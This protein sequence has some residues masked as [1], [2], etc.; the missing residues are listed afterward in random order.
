MKG[1]SLKSIDSPVIE[2]ILSLTLTEDK[3]KF[4][5]AGLKKGHLLLYNRSKGG[6]RV[7]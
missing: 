7:I 6:K 3:G 5:V 1:F 2:S 4:L